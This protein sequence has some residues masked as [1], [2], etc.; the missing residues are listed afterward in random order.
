M[1]SPVRHIT[2]DSSYRDR[3]LYP[4]PTD[5]VVNLGTHLNGSAENAIDSTSLEVVTYPPQNPLG[6]SQLVIE[7]I[8]FFTETQYGPSQIQERIYL[9]YM[10]SVP[11]TESETF[12]RLDELPIAS[13]TP[14]T[15]DIEPSTDL[16]RGVIPLGRANNV[17][18]NNYLENVNTG[19]FR[20]II[21][22][23]YSNEQ[24]TLQTV[25]IISYTVSGTNVSIGL[26][27][28][29]DNKPV[30]S[31]VD[32]FYQGK[33]IEF[34][35]G[36][37]RLIL[38]YFLD[39]IGNPIIQIDTPLATPSTI[40][41]SAYIIAP[42][43]W[44]ARIE[45][46]FSTTIPPYPAYRDEL[47]ANNVKYT[48]YGIIDTGKILA[49]ASI[50]NVDGTIG[51]A[52]ATNSSIYYVTS[53]DT[54]GILWN[55]PVVV[56]TDFF[57]TMDAHGIG[58]CFI[59]GNPAIAYAS[60]VFITQNEVY[61]VRASNTAGTAW[62]TPQSVDP[63]NY[64][65]PDTK[66]CIVEAPQLRFVAFFTNYAVGY[67]FIAWTNSS[68]YI[69]LAWGRT[70]YDAPTWERLTPYIFDSVTYFYEGEVLDIGIHTVD[71]IYFNILILYRSSA[72]VNDG[73][74]QQV[75]QYSYIFVNSSA[76][77]ASDRWNIPAG[78]YQGPVRLSGS[79]FR[80]YAVQGGSTYSLL[81]Y[82]VEDANTGAIMLVRQRLSGT[83]GV[84]STSFAVQVSTGDATAPDKLGAVGFSDPLDAADYNDGTTTVAVFQINGTELEVTRVNVDSLEVLYSFVLDYAAISVFNSIA[85][86]SYDQ[87]LVFY[88]ISDTFYGLIPSTPD[89]LK[90]VQYRIRNGSPPSIASSSTT[91]TGGS[92]TRLTVSSSSGVSQT[93]GA[94]VGSY[95][96]VYNTEVN[97]IPTPFIMFNDYRRIV[98]YSGNSTGTTETPPLPPYTFVVS[99]AFTE[100]I[101]RAILEP[102]TITADLTEFSVNSTPVNIAATTYATLDAVLSAIQTALGGSFALSQTDRIVTISNA[103]TFT[104]ER[105]R[106]S[107]TLGFEMETLT[108]S[109]TY[110][111]RYAVSFVN[112]VKWELLTFERDNYAPLTYVGNTVGANQP[113]CY[114]VELTSLVLPN[115]TLSSGRGNRI[116]FYPY[117]MVEFSN[118]TSPTRNVLISNNPYA[119]KVLFHVP[120]TNIVDPQRST[121][122]SLSGRGVVNTIPFKPDD[123]FRLRIILDN[124]ELFETLTVDT[125][126]PFPPDPNIQVSAIIS[127]RRI[128]DGGR[129]RPE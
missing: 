40:G 82:A 118:T 35:D 7:P 125:S 96:H 84:W 38:N 75:D 1:K 114:E 43:N 6:S 23:S 120:I 21:G 52:Y 105:T 126:P 27:T 39:N 26:R 90:G 122:V 72:T 60:G 30:P 51:L 77:A 74:I 62:G 83:T 81:G 63:G 65:S 71:E 48:K 98:K 4:A 95:L 61:Y 115:V 68:G 32:R 124:G 17:Y 24:T 42:E 64:V 50:R 94:Y 110:T 3:T 44:Y 59:D 108:G 85:N 86:T 104:L 25:S 13:T 8:A 128:A 99:E 87:A 80:Y 106:L 113:V 2:I 112:E 5:F 15:T 67:P 91:I 58:L 46:A 93:P 11:N 10:Y 78:V 53:T 20:K 129:C 101:S 45:S 29:S 103:S 92:T 41:S 14:S 109:D 54:D 121:F 66:I 19:E 37:H 56:V 33:F 123:N 70:S 28:L 117:V 55:D 88:Q 97:P 100:D 34:E 12:L 36:V 107:Q 102:I 22:F 69:R 57:W 119:T 111:G 49:T 9:P 89:V 31:N 16:I 47:P 116:A 76:G 79:L 73:A 127:A 18:I